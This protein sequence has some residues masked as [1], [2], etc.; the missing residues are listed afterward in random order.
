MRRETSGCMRASGTAGAGLALGALLA[1]S[2]TGCA[3]GPD[4][5]EFLNRW[6]GKNRTELRADWGEPDYRYNDHRGRETL[7]Y[8]YREVIFES[9]SSG[10]QVVW[11]CLSNFHLGEDGRIVETSSTGN[12]CFPPDNLAAERARRRRRGGLP[13]D[14]PP[15]DSTQ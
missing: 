15:S 10:R 7:Q 9:L 2:A 12:H 4:Y 11:W 5:G 13:P 6:Q 14:I 8:V 3:A 1:A